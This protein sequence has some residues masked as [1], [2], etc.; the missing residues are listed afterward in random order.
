MRNLAYDLRHN[1]TR[2]VRA[3]LTVDLPDRAQLR[4][5]EDTELRTIQALDFFWETGAAN[6]FA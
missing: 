3:T 2:V 1:N 5:A 4:P 6:S